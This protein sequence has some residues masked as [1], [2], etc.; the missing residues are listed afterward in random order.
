MPR[1]GRNIVVIGPSCAGKSTLA[2][3]LASRLGLRFVELDALWWEPGWQPAP[4]DVFRER[5]ASATG[6]DGWVVAGNYG[7]VRDLLW[8]R[9]HTIVW[10]DF[11]LSL[12]LR[13]MVRRTWRRWRSRELLW[14]TNRE[15]LR[16]QLI[17]HPSRSLFAYT[18]RTHRRR[19]CEFERLMDAP[20]FAQATRVRLR[21]PQELEQWVAVTFPE[22]VTAGR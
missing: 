2:R 6:G 18:V 13:R 3:V 15:R 1:A 9:A 12:V 21:S 22:P 11:P 20:D 8:P 4:L 5:V 19:R 10:L 7:T 14:G 17:P 16:D